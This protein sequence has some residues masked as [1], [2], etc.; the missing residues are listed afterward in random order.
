MKKRLVK[1]GKQ[2]LNIRLAADTDERYTPEIDFSKIKVGL[3]TLPN[4]I[5]TYGS[6][7]RANPRLGTKANV[8]K[9]ITDGDVK[10]MR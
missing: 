2:D 7:Q 10:E 3:Q 5:V 9:A 8:L 4:A 6:Y 1:A